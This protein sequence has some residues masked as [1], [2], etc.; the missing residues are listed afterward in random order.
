MASL[1]KL[2]PI[3]AG[4]PIPL[5]AAA[6]APP[7]AW[8]G[9]QANFTQATL[10]DGRFLTRKAPSPPPEDEA[11]SA[12]PAAPALRQT[13]LEAAL[14]RATAAQRVATDSGVSVT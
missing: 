12:P 14:A 13:T 3:R 6:F 7:S 5:P 4:D 8:P 11:P 1:W 2:E 10:F 9:R